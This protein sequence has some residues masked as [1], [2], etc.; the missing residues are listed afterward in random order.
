MSSTTRDGMYGILL[1]RYI[2]NAQDD[3][4]IDYVNRKPIDCRKCNL[5]FCNRTQNNFNHGIRKDNSSGV[6][7]SFLKN[8]N[9]WQARIA[10]NGKII[11]LGNFEHYED[12]VKARMIAEQ[13]YCKEFSINGKR[14][15]KWWLTTTITKLL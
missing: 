4:E 13:K 9:K 5:R 12:D 7:C 2:L 10:V 8:R 11:S 3:S 14:G 1:H 6:G 15:D